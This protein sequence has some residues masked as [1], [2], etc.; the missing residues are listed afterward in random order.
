MEWGGGSSNILSLENIVNR[1]LAE[2]EK[3][4]RNPLVGWGVGAVKKEL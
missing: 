2:Q 3:L 1:D 4:K